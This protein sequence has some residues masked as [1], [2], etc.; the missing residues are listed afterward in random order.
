MLPVGLMPT[1]AAWSPNG[2]AVLV[3]RVRRPDGYSDPY[4]CGLDRGTVVQATLQGD[5]GGVG[6]G[7][8]TQPWPVRTGSVASSGQTD[9]GLIAAFPAH[10]PPLAWRARDG[11]LYSPAEVD[12]QAKLWRIDAGLLTAALPHPDGVRAVALAD[13]GAFLTLD[14][15]GTVRVWEMPQGAQSRTRLGAALKLCR[16]RP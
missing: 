12:R 8:T 3:R 2:E 11:P 14:E 4:P 15:T 5:G 16:G 7:G 10:P 13:T 6:S 1:C 9:G